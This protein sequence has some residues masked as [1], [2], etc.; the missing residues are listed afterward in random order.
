MSLH[1]LFK[2]VIELPWERAEG[3][4]CF[5]SRLTCIVSKTVKKK[6]YDLSIMY[7][8]TGQV[9]TIDKTDSFD[10]F[11]DFND[12]GQLCCNRIHGENERSFLWDTHRKFRDLDRFSPRIINNS[13]QMIRMRTKEG[14]PLALWCNGEIIELPEFDKFFHIS[15]NDKC[16]ILGKS[17]EGH[18]LLLTPK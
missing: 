17:K 9:V 15:I 14:Y 4:M 2:A 10:E 13:G 7:I 6:Y 1:H 8:G 5:G 3:T 18:A 16:E 11:L 12:K